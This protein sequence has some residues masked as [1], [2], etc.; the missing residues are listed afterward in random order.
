MAGAVEVV[1]AATAVCESE[2][3]PVLKLQEIARLTF[4]LYGDAAAAGLGDACPAPPQGTLPPN[5]FDA[6]L[7]AHLSIPPTVAA[8]ERLVHEIQHEHGRRHS[9]S[10]EIASSVQRLTSIVHNSEQTRLAIT[11]SLDR[12]AGALCHGRSQADQ[13]AASRAAAAHSFLESDLTRANALAATIR[14]MPDGYGHWT[15]NDFADLRRTIVVDG[16]RLAPAEP[17]TQMRTWGDAWGWVAQQTDL[18]FRVQGIDSLESPKATVLAVLAEAL[19]RANDEVALAESALE[20]ARSQPEQWS[21]GTQQA[22]N[23]IR[24]RAEQAYPP[25]ELVPEA[26]QPVRDLY[27][28]ELAMHRA[29]QEVL[30]LDRVA[31]QQRQSHDATWQRVRDLARRAH[32]S[33]SADPGVDDL[34]TRLDGASGSWDARDSV[35]EQLTELLLKPA[36]TNEADAQRDL[37]LRREEQRHAIALVEV[38]ADL[39]GRATAVAERVR[40]IAAPPARIMPFDG[41]WTHGLPGS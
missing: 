18:R 27:D 29:G 32:A 3:G 7:M 1:A 20:Q 14:S 12:L 19:S 16:L 37:E 23:E 9:T 17:V 35:R 6:L 33:P 22:A 31:N 4:E 28:A 15:D 5:G 24:A 11:T 26:T 34:R 21:Q 8:M 13:T 25:A 36:M 30:R 41:R 38:A 39:A 10:N 2:H 40:S